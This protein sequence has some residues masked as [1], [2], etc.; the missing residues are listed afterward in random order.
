[1]SVKDC[2]HS[3]TH[4]C[5]PQVPGDESL[6][7]SCAD[8]ECESDSSDSSSSTS[9]S[10]AGVTHSSAFNSDDDDD[11]DDDDEQLTNGNY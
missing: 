4:G 1:M 7:A 3:S 5:T 11:D 2:D 8:H 10:S 6:C 9:E